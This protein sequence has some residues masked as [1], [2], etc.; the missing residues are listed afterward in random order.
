M[1][2]DLDPEMVV[3]LQANLKLD[4]VV[5]ACLQ[6]VLQYVQMDL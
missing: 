3:L 2:L 1:T 4:G 6:V 5:Q